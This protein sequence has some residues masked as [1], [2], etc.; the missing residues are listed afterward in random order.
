MVHAAVY[1]DGGT[2]SPAA[3][4]R[5]SPPPAGQERW[6]SQ[7]RPLRGGRAITV[8]AINGASYGIPAD[9]S[10]P[11]DSTPPTR[12]RSLPITGRRP[13]KAGGDRHGRSQTA[14]EL[15]RGAQP[16]TSRFRAVPLRGVN[17]G[18]R[19]DG[20]CR[21]QTVT[22]AGAW[23][24]DVTTVRSSATP[25]RFRGRAPHRLGSRAYAADFNEVKAV[26][27][28]TG[29][30]RTPDQTAAA[31]Y[32]GTTQR[33]RDDGEHH[34]LESRAARAATLDDH[35]PVARS[36]VHERRRCADRDLARQG[37]IPAFLA[38]LP[39]DPRGRRDRR[40][41]RDRGRPGLDSADRLAALPRASERALD[42]RR[43][44]R[45]H[46]AALLRPG[47]GDVQRH[48]APAA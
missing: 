15:T 5:T 29:S 2:R 45:A 11:R 47:P 32:W 34:P 24:K 40:Q 25:D 44:G 38:A 26:G 13:A 7:A 9:P 30:T 4:S 33:D 22:D 12:R 8:L 28:A 41:P 21:R 17:G 3:T 31:E 36:R 16:G 43:C 39:R 19:L 37:A 10:V 20:W 1:D 27:R 6:Y 23:L 42:V 46:D 14:T 18:W 35:A 48:H